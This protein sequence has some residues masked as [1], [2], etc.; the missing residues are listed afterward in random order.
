MTDYNFATLDLAL[1]LFLQ[2]QVPVPQTFNATI[3]KQDEM[4]LF[5]LQNHKFPEKARIRYHFNGQR[6]FDAVRQVV[7]WKFQGFNSIHSFLDFASGYGRFTRFLLQELNPQQVWISDIY[8]NA[9][10]FQQDTF[11]VHGILST[12]NPADY[13]LNQ[14]FDCI[15]A[16]SFFSHIPEKTFTNWM[17][18][19]YN[20]LTPEGIL[21]FS[22]HDRDLLPPESQIQSDQLLFIPQSES[23]S[24]DFNEYG[25]SYVGEVFVRK[26]VENISHGEAFCYRISKGICRYQDLY[27]IG[28]QPTPE[29]SDL[30]FGHHPWGRLEYINLDSEGILTLKG[31]VSELNDQSKIEKILVSINGDLVQQIKPNLN[32]D[33]TSEYSW[34]MQINVPNLSAQDVI[35]IKAINSKGL[36]WVF[37]AAP[38]EILQTAMM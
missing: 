31:S 12:V 35:L 29:F 34:S 36:E 1:Q 33:S 24:L 13:Q 4:Y 14:T 28:K 8:E 19:L 17:K 26:I 2:D 23:L 6:I 27:L 21:L 7:Q 30:D 9:V 3:N 11:G 38:L 37:E 32:P 10:K 22:V 20:L 18:T 15:L 5:A 25:T 16:C